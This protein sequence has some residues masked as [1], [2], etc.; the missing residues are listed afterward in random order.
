MEGR[1]GR[2]RRG[3]GAAAGCCPA[4]TDTI[5][6]Y[7]THRSTFEISK[8]NTCNIRLNT[9]ETLETCNIRLNIDETLETCA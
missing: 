7:A 5:A 4:V 9:D 6:T 8:C 2:E 1:E 3:E